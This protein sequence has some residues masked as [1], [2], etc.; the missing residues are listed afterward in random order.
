MRRLELVVILCSL[1]Q[2]RYCQLFRFCHRGVFHQILEQ[3]CPYGVL[4]NEQLQIPCF[5]TMNSGGGNGNVAR[6]VALFAFK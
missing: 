2:Q 4:F 1:I 3:D 5:Y 6:Y